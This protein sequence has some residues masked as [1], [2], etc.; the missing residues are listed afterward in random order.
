[1]PLLSYLFFC[2]LFFL[3]ISRVL[4]F[5]S[6]CDSFHFSVVAQ[7]LLT[8]A[9]MNDFSLFYWFIHYGL[10]AC[11]GSVTHSNEFMFHSSLTTIHRRRGILQRNEKHRTHNTN[12]D[13][14]VFYF[15]FL[16]PET[17]SVSR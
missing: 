12:D 17:L 7:N 9:Q 14:P 3:F 2:V 11:H 5:C 10:F 16:L 1:M 15:S 6:I 8:N 4:L 13:A